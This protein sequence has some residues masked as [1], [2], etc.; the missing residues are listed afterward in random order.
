MATP[1]FQNKAKAL[2]VIPDS[3]LSDPTSIHQQS[4]DVLLLF[5]FI[6]FKDLF[7]CDRHRERERQ[8]QRQR[9]KQA[10]CREPDAGNINE[11]QGSGIGVR[12][13]VID[14]TRVLAY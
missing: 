3:C 13:Y 14:V 8:R 12:I 5:F 11:S 10:P 1:S 9:E 4:R 7:I 2:G 6:F